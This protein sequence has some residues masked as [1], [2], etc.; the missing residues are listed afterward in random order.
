LSRSTRKS[1]TF[2]DFGFS[3]GS[4][5]T[6]YRWDGNL[7]DVYVQNFLLTN[8]LVKEFWKSVAFAEKNMVSW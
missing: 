7:C 3:H 4:V 2:L 6:Y 5:A 1:V 8:H